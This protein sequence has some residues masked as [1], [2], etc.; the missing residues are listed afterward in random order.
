MRS[1]EI[2][3]S[4]RRMEEQVIAWRRDLHAHPELGFEEVRTAGVVAQALLGMGIEVETGVARTGVVGRLGRGRPVIAI[5]ADMDAVP[6]QE[7]N[8][9]SYA[10]QNAGVMH[11]CGHDGHVAMLLGAAQVLAEMHGRPAG[12]IRFLFQPSEE[13]TDSEGNSGAM[14]M[15]RDGAM[16]GVDAVIALHLE[17]MIRAGAMHVDRGAYVSGSSDLFVGTIIGNGGHGAVPHETIDTFSLLAQ[18]IQAINAIVS[19]RIDPA[20]PA[21]ISIGTIHGGLSPSTIPDRVEI[22]GGA[23]SYDPEV[24]KQLLVELER[25]FSLTRALGGDYELHIRPGYP[26]IF[27]DAGVA[28]VIADTICDLWG[29]KAL[30]EPL[31]NLGGEDFSRMTD[32]APGAMF[33]LGAQ[34][35]DERRGHHSPT[36]DIDE[37]VLTVGASVLAESACRLLQRY[38]H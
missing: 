8:D 33:I 25:A 6:V 24:R 19:R 14:L 32:M 11:G 10:S 31:V 1:D 5:R 17:S 7:D 15:V 3:Q 4:T 29:R 18:V 35:G 9:L 34:I 36:F 2:L 26:P 21:T 30:I 22:R 27:N 16:D 20:Q 12:E 13:R 23:R 28:D 38:Q 37:S